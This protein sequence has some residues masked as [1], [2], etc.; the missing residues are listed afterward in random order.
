MGK[1]NNGIKCDCHRGREP[2]YGLVC[3]C[4][5]SHFS[6][7]SSTLYDPMGWSLPSSSVHGILQARILEWVSSVQFSCSVMPDSLQPHGLQHT[8]FP[9]HHQL[10]NLAQTQVHQVS[11]AIQPS[12]PLLSPSAAFSLSQHQGLFQ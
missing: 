2:D 5:L 1:V 11:D 6:D 10:P 4:V 12:H 3:V 9:V 7:F 8:R